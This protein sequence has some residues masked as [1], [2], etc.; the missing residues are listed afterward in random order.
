MCALLA[1]DGLAAAILSE[2]QDHP[3]VRDHLPPEVDCPAG[4]TAV[5]SIPRIE[6]PKDIGDSSLQ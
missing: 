4:I 3:D 1:P 6:G 2:K 5:V